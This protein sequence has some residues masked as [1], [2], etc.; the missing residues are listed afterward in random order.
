MISKMTRAACTKFLKFFAQEEPAE[1]EYMSETFRLFF[2]IDCINCVVLFT[3][4]RPKVSTFLIPAWATRKRLFTDPKVKKNV[5]GGAM[6]LLCYNLMVF[7]NDIID[8]EFIELLERIEKIY[9]LTNN[10]WKKV[11]LECAE[12]SISIELRLEIMDQEELL[13]LQIARKDF[14]AIIIKEKES[15]NDWLVSR[16]A[17]ITHWIQLNNTPNISP[18]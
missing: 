1:L 5:V 2:E 11:L 9:S 10:P 12:K 6:G 16:Y 18:R 17:D 4:S 3:K 7:E 15:L 13:V 8:D 14:E